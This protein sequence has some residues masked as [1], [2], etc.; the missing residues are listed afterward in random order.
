MI[1]CDTCNVWYHPECLRIPAVSPIG[2]SLCVNCAIADEVVEG[3]VYALVVYN[4]LLVFCRD[5]V[6]PD[7][8]DNESD[9]QLLGTIDFVGDVLFRPQSKLPFVN[10]SHILFYVGK[11]NRRP[12]SS[13]SAEYKRKLVL[14][15]SALVRKLLDIVAPEQPQDAL[16]ILVTSPLFSSMRK[17]NL[18]K[19]QTHGFITAL[20]T[21]YSNSITKPDGRPRVLSTIAR[22]LSNSEIQQLFRRP[23]GSI[24]TSQEIT[25]VTH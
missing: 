24:P 3:C 23:N 17:H 20:A 7:L 16:L 1:L 9:L 2:A 11:Y 19:K 8:E 12:F 25:A 18:L 14:K 6:V 4:S 13:Y 21:T 5:A 10:R 22:F 15:I